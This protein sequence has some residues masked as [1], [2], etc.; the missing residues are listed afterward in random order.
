MRLRRVQE[1]GGQP[2]SRGLPGTRHRSADER[3]EAVMGREISECR[4]GEEGLPRAELSALGCVWGRV[5]VLL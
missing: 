1:Q 5:F 2:R 4:G 3:R